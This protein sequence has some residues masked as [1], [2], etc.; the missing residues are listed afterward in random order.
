MTSTKAGIEGYRF[1]ATAAG[2][3]QAGGTRLDM[4][5]IV[6]DRPVLVAGVTTTNLVCAAPVLIARERFKIGKI[7]AVLANSGNANAC[8][9]PDGERAARELIREAANQLGIGDDEIL[10]M[11]TGVIGTPMPAARILPH[12]RSLVEGLDAYRAE[13]FARAIMTTDTTPKIVRREVQRPGG[14]LKMLGIAK[15]AGMIAPR[16][17]TMLAVA[18]TNA[19]PEIEFLRES[20]V[21]AAE[22]SFNRITID[23]DMSTNDTLAVLAGGGAGSR[24]LCASAADREAFSQTLEELCKALATM[25]VMDGE[26]AGKLVEIRVNRGRDDC[27]A[28]KAARAIAES[29]LVKTAF[30]GSDPNWGRIVAAAG[31]SGARFDPT[32]TD[33][34]IGEVRVLEGGV[35]ASGEWESK[36]HEVM[37]ERRFSVTL[38][39][40]AGTGTATIL[41]TDLTEEYVRINADYRS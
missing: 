22:R 36:A 34:W 31:R 10:P 20:A 24:T 6:A 2:V 26:G 39:L 27:D 33:L 29:L 19:E 7:R 35:P 28:D 30:R 9:G 4:G 1:S 40:H 25:I 14:T 32:V 12:I 5:L 15:G 8:T 17:A 13:D 21:R 16:M 23:G 38:D 41:T 11:S 18:L 37:K 3:K